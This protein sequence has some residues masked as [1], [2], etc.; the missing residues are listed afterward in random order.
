LTLNGCSRLDLVPPIDASAS[1]RFYFETGG[2]SSLD[3]PG[4]KIMTISEERVAHSGFDSSLY[5]LPSRMQTPSSWS[6]WVGWS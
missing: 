6:A 4:A 5:S 3:T 1:D 2:R